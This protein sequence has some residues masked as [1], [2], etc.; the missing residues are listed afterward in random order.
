[1]FFNS[2]TYGELE[3]KEDGVCHLKGENKPAPQKINEDGKSLFYNSIFAVYH[4]L[5]KFVDFFNL[6]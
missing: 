5:I 3:G 1:M 4:G 2:I 6:T